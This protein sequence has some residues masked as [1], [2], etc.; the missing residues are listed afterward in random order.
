MDR[1]YFSAAL[2]INAIDPLSMACLMFQERRKKM[3]QRNKEIRIA[4]A[5][6]G[7]TGRDL[8][9][10]VRIPESYVSFILRGRMLPTK[11]EAIRIA[12]ALDREPGQLFDHII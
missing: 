3:I 12:S 8:S 1:M 11:D 10:L 7:F 9:R 4:L 6:K 5:A 2:I